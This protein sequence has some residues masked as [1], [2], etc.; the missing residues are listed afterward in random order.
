ME[1]EEIIRGIFKPFSES[2]EFPTPGSFSGFF[3]YILPDSFSAVPRKNS[4]TK[5]SFSDVGLNRFKNF[6]SEEFFFNHEPFG[7]HIRGF[8]KNYEKKKSLLK[9]AKKIMSEIIDER[10]EA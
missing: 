8:V 6:D 2:Q 7:F 3:Q 4:F 1:P 5:R 10:H 9:H